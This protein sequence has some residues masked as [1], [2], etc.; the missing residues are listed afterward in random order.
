MARETRGGPASE[1]K[2]EQY[3]VWVKAEPREVLRSADRSEDKD[4]S[5]EL[6]D[7]EPAR[8][9]GLELPDVSDE[10]PLTTEEEK[11]L[12]ELETQIES[13]EGAEETL[14]PLDRA[15]DEELP[16]LEVEEG[17]GDE[18]E[19]TLSD[20]L[21]AEEHFDDLQALEDEL[22]SVTSSAG[23]ASEVHGQS[24]E[25]LARIEEELRSIRTDLTELKRELAGLRRSPA[26]KT[27]A[28]SHA[29][30]EAAGKFFDEDEDETIALTGD[31]LDNILNTAEITEETAEIPA[32]GE[33]A[34]ALAPRAEAPADAAEEDILSYETPILEEDRLA[35]SEA[36]GVEE[37]LG[38]LE[39]EAEPEVD[40]DLAAD[41][42]LE[43][44]LPAPADASGIGALDASGA[45]ELPAELEL[46]SLP[47]I[48]LVEEGGA[49]AEI[50]ADL[51]TVSELEA[52][53]EELSA[54]DETEEIAEAEEIPEIETP[55]RTVEEPESSVDLAALA[56]ENEESL[57]T[58]D[59]VGPEDLEIG[60][61]EAVDDDETDDKIEIAFEAE[62]A[63]A[64]RAPAK[65]ARSTAPAAPASPL[66]QLLEVEEVPE[67]E[68]A[69]ARAS[70]ASSGVT[71]AS[72]VPD[73][74][75]EEIR[76]VLK[77]MDH[78]LEALPEDKIQEFA[79]SDYFVMYK[80]LFEDLGLGE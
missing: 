51:E 33:E 48:E 54:I 22:A 56:T 61:L 42:V 19:V 62:P 58:L 27:G 23:A 49:P 78:L 68:P 76:A 60:E 55:A 1:K 9:A 18:V 37:V 67:I 35:P 36:N 73:D 57:P 13:T 63:A 52:E 40:L 12:D 3:G 28:A 14:V 64:A 2:L 50:E 75:K 5:L 65:P 71:G 47:E 30:T 4:D 21:P 45:S 26:E 53:P 38:E 20:S 46:E 69:P 72:A 41:L 31:E 15:S 7:L 10:S 39:A 8:E 66:E 59:L 77:Y 79:G 70:P 16:E 17:H 32:L 43:E 11:L 6:S 34:P 74:L 29:D 25:I 44:T 24:A 80:K